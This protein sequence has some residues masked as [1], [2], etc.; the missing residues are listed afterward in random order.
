M[1]LSF[2][3]RISNYLPRFSQVH[4]MH[5]KKPKHGH[6][7]KLE[8]PKW[9]K[10]NEEVESCVEWIAWIDKST[11]SLKFFSQWNFSI[12]FISCTKK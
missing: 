3:K 11:F 5:I 12:V 10:I 7:F 8:M 9:M 2:Q 1:Y 4:E 6:F